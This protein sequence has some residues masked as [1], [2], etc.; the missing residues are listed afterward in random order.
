MKKI[1][2]VIIC[3]M[4]ITSGSISAFA[5]K[6]DTDN[7]TGINYYDATY[8]IRNLENITIPNNT[9]HFYSYG[10]GLDPEASITFTDEVTLKEITLGYTKG[11]VNS[12]YL[13]SKNNYDLFMNHKDGGCSC[14][15]QNYNNTGGQYEKVRIRPSRFINELNNDG[16]YTYVYDN[17]ITHKYNFTIES[18]SY[19][20]TLII[21]SGAAINIVAPDMYGMVEIVVSKKVADEA[22]CYS[23]INIATNEYE[24]SSWGDL[25]YYLKGITIGDVDK[26]GYVDIYDATHM[27]KYCAGLTTFGM[28]EERCCDIN[29]DGK[30]DITDATNIQKALAGLL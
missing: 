15:S 30:Y 29:G 14:R 18:N 17:G 19:H 25:S 27:Q 2:S 23:Y 12:L 22:S 1:L 9:V 26:N 4:L 7:S 10:N 3:L 24:N 5:Q 13:P 8:P 6:T 21:I 20:S 28:I 16:T 11:K